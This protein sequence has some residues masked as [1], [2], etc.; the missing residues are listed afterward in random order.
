M[1]EEEQIEAIKSWWKKHGNTVSTVILIV[2]MCFAGFRYWQWNKQKVDF[3]A[4]NLYEQMLSAYTNQDKKAIVSRANKL[5]QNHSGTVYGD[6]AHL[7]LA[8]VAAEKKLYDKAATHL[9]AVIKDDTHSALT[10]VAKIRLARVLLAKKEYQSALSAIDQVSDDSYISLVKELRGDIF[11]AMGDFNKAK[12]AYEEALTSSR[13]QKM[14]NLFLEM[15]T[16]DVARLQMSEQSNI[17]T[18]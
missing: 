18:A 6:T 3:Q 12:L 8:K 9:N 5:V 10:Q 7:T 4:S 15:K 11:T 16:N 14:G 13:K 17:K 1:T 2:V